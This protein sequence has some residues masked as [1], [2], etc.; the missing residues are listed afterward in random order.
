VK[1]GAA[2]W[3]QDGI[4]KALADSGV[5]WFYDWG[6]VPNGVSAPG[7]VG[8][9]PMIWGAR[10]VGASTLATAKK[11]GSTLLGFNEPDLAAQSNLSVGAALDLGPELE[12]T[13]RRPGSPAAAWGADQSGQ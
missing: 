1:K 10:S 3:A 2:L 4:T 12:A 11:N 9:V 5:S 8:F 7:G 13:K 6:A